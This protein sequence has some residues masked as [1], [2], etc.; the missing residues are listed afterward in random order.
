[1]LIAMITGPV[2]GLWL[3]LHYEYWILTRTPLGYPVVALCCGDPVTLNLQDWPLHILQQFINGINVGVSQLK[4][5]DLGL[6]VG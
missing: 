6:G 2:Q 1:M 4:A 5:L 3:L